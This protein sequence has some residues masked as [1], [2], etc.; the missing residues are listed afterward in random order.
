MLEVDAAIDYIGDMTKF[1]KRIR[2]CSLIFHDMVS[3]TI[4]PN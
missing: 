4:P 1:Q 3:V 2:I